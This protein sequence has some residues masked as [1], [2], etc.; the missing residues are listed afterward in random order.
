MIF[1]LAIFLVL[2]PEI[3]LI[4]LP[5]DAQPYFL[6]VILLGLSS[7][8]MRNNNFSLILLPFVFILILSIGSFIT[9]IFNTNDVFT[10]FRSLFGYVSSF[11]VLL[12]L[13]R[14]RE[15]FTSR[16]MIP[17]LDF[18]VKF[19]YLGF[20]LNLMGLNRVVQLFINRSEFRFDGARGLVSFYSEQSNMV[21]ACFVI[22]FLYYSA[23]LGIK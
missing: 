6:I 16:I 18:S 7:N 5:S 14:Y 4:R 9:S 11:I 15:Y 20:V 21:T 8:F 1:R 19:I 10:L 3:G 17:I 13:F 22:V 23:F 12:F 2:F